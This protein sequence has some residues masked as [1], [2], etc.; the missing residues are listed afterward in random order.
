MF[1]G[2]ANDVEEGSRAL[3]AR[4]KERFVT[5]RLG[6]DPPVEGRLSPDRTLLE[7]F[8]SMRENRRIRTPVSTVASSRN[9][10]TIGRTGSRW[11]FN[12]S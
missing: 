7:A 6:Y 10:S 5:L 1:I 4:M 2:T 12:S 9:R 11:R 3:A 8:R